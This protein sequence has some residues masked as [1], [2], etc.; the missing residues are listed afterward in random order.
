MPATIAIFNVRVAEIIAAPGARGLQTSSNY[1]MIVMVKPSE[2]FQKQDIASHTCAHM[3]VDFLDTTVG[4][5]LEQLFG[6]WWKYLDQERSRENNVTGPLHLV[7]LDRPIH[8]LAR[9]AVVFNDPSIL[10]QTEVSRYTIVLRYHDALL[11]LCDLAYAAMQ[12]GKITPRDDR[13]GAPVR[14]PQAPDFKSWG[15]LRRAVRTRDLATATELL[16]EPF[17]TLTDH[18]FPSLMIS[19]V[20]FSTWAVAEGLATTG[21]IARLLASDTTSAAESLNK[22]QVVAQRSVTSAQ[23]IDEIW[24]ARAKQYGNEIYRR[25]KATGCD[26][27]KS[28]I[29]TQIA[30]RF[31]EEGIRGTRGRLSVETIVR[32]GLKG[33]QKPT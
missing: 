7:S 11:L 9:R 12:A 21:E 33:W 14:F 16:S 5:D 2:E 17:A 23:S 24:K 19:V 30:A 29:A 8:A 3:S 22:R 26:P 32:H 18:L 13:L 15:R 28:D 27:S 4:S 31:S 10:N 20:E 25:D 1:G 6:S